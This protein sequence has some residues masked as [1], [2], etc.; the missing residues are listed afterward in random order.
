ME[1]ANQFT[2]NISA[3][4]DEDDTSSKRSSFLKRN[5]F[6]NG[7]CLAKFGSSIEKSEKFAISLR[8]QKKDSIIQVL[9]GKR[10]S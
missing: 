8:K 10:S 1:S 5:F 9:R 4:Q 6:N 2:F 3:R 7:D